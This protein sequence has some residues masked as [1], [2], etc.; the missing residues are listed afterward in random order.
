MKA[1]IVEGRS[2]EAKVK[3]AVPCE[4]HFIILGGIRFKKEEK[5]AIKEA[6]INCEKVYTLT[7]PDSA[8]DRVAAAIKKEFPEVER[9]NVKKENA[10]ILSK[11][12]YKYGVEYCGYKYLNDLFKEVGLI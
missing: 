2:D 7:D 11:D 5:Q 4:Y 3:K 10:R 9:I 6:L 8:G 12:G 1:I